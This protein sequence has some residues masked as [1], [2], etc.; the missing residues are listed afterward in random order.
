MWSPI[1]Y[2][3]SLAWSGRWSSKLLVDGRSVNCD[4]SS[5]PK[6]QDHQTTF[7]PPKYSSASCDGGKNICAKVSCGVLVQPQSLALVSFGKAVGIHGRY[8]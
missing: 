3:I 6:D 4:S 2:N 1:P 8:K 5:E 7:L